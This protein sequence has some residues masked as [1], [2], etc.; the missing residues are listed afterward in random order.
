MAVGSAARS[1]RLRL[2]VAI[3]RAPVTMFGSGR[4]R[5]PAGG[6]VARQRDRPGKSRRTVRA[7]SPSRRSLGGAPSAPRSM[8]GA[9]VG[10]G[11]RCP[12]TF[13]ALAARLTATPARRCRAACC[14]G[15]RTCRPVARGRELDA[16]LAKPFTVSPWTIESAALKTS[17]RRVRLRP[18][19]GSRH[20]CRGVDLHRAG[21]LRQH[22]GGRD[23]RRGVAIAKVMRLRSCRRAGWRIAGGPQRALV[24]RRPGV[25][26]RSR[27]PRRRRPTRR[28]RD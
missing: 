24:R 21:D 2:R 14:T 1:G 7:A 4:D 17:P 11:W 19:R 20:G 25:G 26:R 5:V 6:R 13:P 10:A 18:R 22:R 27:R 28:P 23:H 16:V 8:P 12:I 15:T 9:P 3:T